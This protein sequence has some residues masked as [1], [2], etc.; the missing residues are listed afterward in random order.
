MVFGLFI[1]LIF[2]IIFVVIYIHSMNSIE[3]FTTTPINID[4]SNSNLAGMYYDT[5]SAITYDNITVSTFALFNNLDTIP[6]GFITMI[7][8]VISSGQ[9]M[10]INGEQPVIPN[11]WVPCDGNTYTAIDPITKNT[12]QVVSPNFTGFIP[13]GATTSGVLIPGKKNGIEQGPEGVIGMTY[14]M[15][16][17][18][19]QQPSSSS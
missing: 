11:G 14:I 7:Y 15:R 12:K 13:Y 9:T 16:F 18:G 10:S 5:T 2:V 3:K 19:Y 4:Y 6:D 1:M 8:K 17:S